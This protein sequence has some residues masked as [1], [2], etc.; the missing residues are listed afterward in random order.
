[1]RLD[2]N[3]SSPQNTPLL[4]HTRAQNSKQKIRMYELSNEPEQGEEQSVHM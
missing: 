2:A 1:M 4:R 3:T